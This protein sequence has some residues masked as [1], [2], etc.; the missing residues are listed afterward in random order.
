MGIRSRIFLIIFISLGIGILISS[1]VAERDLSNTFQEQIL[2]ELEKQASLLV[3]VVDEV[4]S[5]GDINVADS[6]ADRLGDASNSRI[7]FILNNG[8]VI[9]DSNVNKS[10]VYLLDNHRNRSEINDALVFG[11]GW[12]IRYSDTLNQQQ[13]YFAITDNNEESPNVI[14]IAVPYT[15]VDDVTSSLDLSILLVAIVSFAVATIASA[16]A[17]N[18]AYTSIAD[19]ANATSNIVSSKGK[20]SYIK[21]LPTSRTD[22]FGTVAKSISQISEDLKSTINLVTKQRN[23]FGSVLDDLGDGIIVADQNGNITFENE[24]FSQVL[25]LESVSGKNLAKLN[26][27]ALEYLYKRAKK[28]KRADI[29]FE[30]ELKDKTIRWVL[31]TMNQSKTTK[32]FILVVHDITQL[33]RFSEMRRDFVSNVS[34]EL[35]TPVSV[36]RA[37]AETLVDGALEDKKQAKV[38]AKAILHNAERLSDMVTAL[39]DLSRIEYGELKLNIEELDINAEIDHAINSLSNLG[40]K[41]NISINCSCSKGK[42]VLA[43]KGALERI[44]NNLIENA[45][46]YSEKDSEINIYTK[47]VKDYLEISITDEGRGIPDDEQEFIFD[48][49]YRTAEARATEKNGSGLGLAIV[50]NLVQSLNGEVGL[51]NSKDKGSIFWFTL[52]LKTS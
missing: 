3:E 30:I 37:N 35:R 5:I 18:Y 15:Y 48:R 23:Q 39:L 14:R 38:F 28:K 24:Q 29:E 42:T 2:L 32:E 27:K 16:V 1:I 36:M 46:K 9:G 10:D 47:K 22:E 33:R 43:D 25:D 11:T 44:L 17:A 31:G 41:K 51:K 21:A 49:F 40:K 34:H 4:D 52:P 13:L 6:L 45:F 19:L 8:T 12:S 7:T 26:I 50:R 20:K